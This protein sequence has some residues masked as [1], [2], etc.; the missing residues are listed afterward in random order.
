M[1]SMKK[2]FKEREELIMNEIA[3]FKKV[4]FYQFK[5]DIQQYITYVKNKYG[6]KFYKK[7]YQ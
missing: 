5:K 4:S 2:T 6:N 3:E 7:L 1:I